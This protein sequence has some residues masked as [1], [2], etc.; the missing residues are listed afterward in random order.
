MNLCFNQ[1]AVLCIRMARWWLCYVDGIVE[2][3]RISNSVSKLIVFEINP[4]GMGIFT[5]FSIWPMILNQ[6]IGRIEFL[7]GVLWNISNDDF[8]R[9]VRFSRGN[10]LSNKIEIEK[11]TETTGK[12]PNGNRMFNLF[13]DYHIFNFEWEFHSKS[14]I[15]ITAFNSSTSNS[16]CSH[17]HAHT[18]LTV[19]QFGNRILPQC[20]Y[21][22]ESEFP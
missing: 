9:W 20:L 8:I 18:R 7:I 6:C 17:S 22:F 11:I 1:T 15:L 12:T 21:D 3:G 16:R 13:C 10:F 5:S 19:L 14:W 2:W 4:I